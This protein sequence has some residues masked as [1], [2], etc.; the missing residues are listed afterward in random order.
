MAGALLLAAGACPVMWPSFLLLPPNAHG[1]QKGWADER[2]AESGCR[3]T[4]L[5]RPMGLGLEPN[6]LRPQARSSLV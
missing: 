6:H 5:D 1:I 3:Q 2:R 4:A